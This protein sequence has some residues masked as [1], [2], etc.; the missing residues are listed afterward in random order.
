MQNKKE[1]YLIN[2]V[3]CIWEAEQNTSAWAV[4]PEPKKT[5]P[6]FANS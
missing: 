3:L 6:Q 2:I 4:K 5:F 1:I